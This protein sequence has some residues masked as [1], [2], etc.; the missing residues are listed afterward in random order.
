MQAGRYSYLPVHALIRPR[1]GDFLF[2]DQDVEIMLADVFQ[3]KL[4]GLQGVVIGALNAMG[5]IDKDIT[6]ILIKEAGKMDIT[7]H[8][9]IDQC[10]D[11]YAGLDTIMRLGCSRVLTSGQALSAPLGTKTIKAMKHYCD[12][13]LIIMAGAGINADNVTDLVKTTGIREVH[14]S[15]KTTRPSLMAVELS[16]VSMGEVDDRYIPITNPEAIRAV[17]EQCQ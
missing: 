3:A 16:E 9:A 15:G 8:R 10:H 1:Q 11:L 17:C 7:F 2:N 5:N 14:L 12:S 13:R 6:R 4:S